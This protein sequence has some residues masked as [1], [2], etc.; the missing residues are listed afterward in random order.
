L[1]LYIKENNMIIPIYRN[2]RR[3]KKEGNFGSLN[4]C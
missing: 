1:E 3:G 4:D 2:R